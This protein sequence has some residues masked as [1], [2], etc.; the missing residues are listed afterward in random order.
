MNQADEVQTAEAAMLRELM[1]M[2]QSL[3]DQVESLAAQRY[4]SAQK[5]AYTVEE[6]AE[7]L[8]RSAWT[9][10]QWCNRGQAQA[11][12]IRGRGRTGEWRIPRAELL[13]LEQD[14]P[15]PLTQC[16]VSR[17]VS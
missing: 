17:T 1:G 11:R 16:L 7:E 8:K 12:K 10:R 15:L 13:R 14:G 2:V 3:K 9:V 4:R 5:D 6:A